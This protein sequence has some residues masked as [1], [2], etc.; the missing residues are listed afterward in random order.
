MTLNVVTVSA[1]G[2]WDNKEASLLPPAPAASPPPLGGGGGEAPVSSLTMVPLALAVPM[3][4][5]VAFDSVTVKPSSGST[6]V[7]PLTLTVMIFELSPDA[8]LTLPEGK[9]PPKSLA[10]APPLG[11]P[12]TS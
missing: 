1:S 4:A 9:L 10:S 6:V 7:S 8:K 2:I 5:P 11:A 3:V 12:D